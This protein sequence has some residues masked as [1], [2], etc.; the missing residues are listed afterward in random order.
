MIEAGFQ[1]EYGIDLSRDLR[2]L[3]WRRFQALLRGLEALA[4]I[5]PGPLEGREALAA[6]SQL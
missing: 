4:A 1:R 5:Q 3:G 2:S 6:F